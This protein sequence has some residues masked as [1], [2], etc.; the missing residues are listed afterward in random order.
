MMELFIHTIK[1]SL[2]MHELKMFFIHEHFDVFSIA[3]LNLLVD[4]FMAVLHHKEF[5]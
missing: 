3:Q 2:E 1:D 4:T 5:K